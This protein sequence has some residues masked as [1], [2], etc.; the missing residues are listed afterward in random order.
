MCSGRDGGPNEDSVGIDETVDTSECM[1]E[2]QGHDGGGR[3]QAR[4]SL[5]CGP[6][7]EKAKELNVV[8]LTLNS[9]FFSPFG[10]C[11]R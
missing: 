10:V 6:N 11:E 2:S 1:V 5:A 7:R 3:R 8:L 9:L 4:H